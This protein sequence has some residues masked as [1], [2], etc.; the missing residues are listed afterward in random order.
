MKPFQLDSKMLTMGGVFYP[1]GW[2]FVMFPTRDDAEK[3]VHELQLRD[4]DTTSIMLVTPED[5]LGKIVHTV[6]GTNIPLPSAGTEGATARKFAELA[7]KGHYAL[8][9]EAPGSEEAERY[10]QVIRKVP[11]SYAEKYRHL[12][13]EDLV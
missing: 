11:F 7:A 3:V 2:I 13:I 5:T 4:Y 12:I 6:G 9:I 8:M 10:M 1:T